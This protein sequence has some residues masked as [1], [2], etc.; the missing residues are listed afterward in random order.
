[1]TVG[2]R[3]PCTSRYK[4]MFEFMRPAGLVPSP[5]GGYVQGQ[6]AG[7]TNC[8]LKKAHD[9]PHANVRGEHPGGAPVPV[10]VPDILDSG[11]IEALAKKLALEIVELEKE[12]GGN[13]AP[14]N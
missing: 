11:H 10:S 9:G 12:K 5:S 13:D 7:K 4:C 6:S 3:Q 14:T 2:D 1:M 8:Y